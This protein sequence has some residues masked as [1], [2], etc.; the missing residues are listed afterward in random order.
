MNTGHS[1]G[2]HDEWRFVDRLS[3]EDLQELKDENEKFFFSPTRFSFISEHKSLRPG[4][5]HMLFGTPGVGKSTLVRTLV[6][7]LSQETKML[8][9]STEETSKQF[10]TMYSYLPTENRPNFN[11]IF[12]KHESEVMNSFR[13]LEK[14]YP[15]VDE[16][17][18]RIDWM[19][20]QSRAKILFFDNITV[21][22]FHRASPEIAENFADSLRDLMIA[23]NIP[24]F[25]VGH[26][27]SK[28]RSGVMF[29]A[30]DMRG[31]KT[32]AIKAE[33]LYCLGRYVREVG[34]HVQTLSAIRIDKCRAHNTSG[35]TYKLFY[36]GKEFSG[37]QLIEHKDFSKFLKNRSK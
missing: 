8:V 21:C 2:I 33:Y 22:R 5:M 35:N 29:E 17:I 19:L 25:C 4:C 16:F 9:Y 28:V 32:L 36:T 30:M 37:D 24:F 34:E 15:T 23:R 31:N 13:R 20:G 6:T 14:R 3:G 11:N 7:D 10:R 12:W 26:T 27:D 18:N 1:G